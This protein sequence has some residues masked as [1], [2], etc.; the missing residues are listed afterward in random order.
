MSL[1]SKLRRAAA[2]AAVVAGAAAARTVLT[3]RRALGAVAPELRHPLLLLPLHLRSRALLR[4]MTAAPVR[5]ATPVPGVDVSRRLVPAHGDGPPVPVYLY[6]PE[7]RARPSG[8]LLWLHGGGFVLGS[9]VTWHDTCSRLAAELGVLVVSVD[10][11]LAPGHLFPAGLDDSYSALAWLHA[12]A[13]EL[14][15]DP[16]RVAV[17][18]ESAGGGLAA[19]L[20]QLAHDRGATPIA[21]QALSYPMLDD[22][23]ALRTHHGGTGTFVWSPISNHF[24][25]TSYLGHPP[26]PAD[27]EPY[28][29]AARRRDLRSLPPAWIGVGDL[30]LFHAEDLEYARRLQEAG[31]QC[32]LHVVPGMYHGADGMMPQ[33]PLTTAFRASMLDALRTAI[34][35]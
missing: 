2:V 26:R 17:A 11:R 35:K 9:A 4:L 6:E 1:T 25:W 20:A 22:R 29:A 31:V 18:G 19:C 28:A 32:E 30:D 15:V 27:P 3:R 14:G 5:P 12:R 21:F 23:T 13:T 24:G 7:G 33:A 10:Y 16:G 8:A 34:S